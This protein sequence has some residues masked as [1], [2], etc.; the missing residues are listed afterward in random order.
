[1]A[2]KEIEEQETDSMAEEVQQFEE[3]L[4]ADL[5]ADVTPDQAKSEEDEGE[6]ESAEQITTES[7][8]QAK[9]AEEEPKAEEAEPEEKPPETYKYG[10]REFTAQEL[11]EDP[12]LLRKIVTGAEQNPHFQKLHREGKEANKELLTRLETI[13]KAQE[14]AR[15]SEAATV[16]PMSPEQIQAHSAQIEAAYLPAVKAYADAG[17]IE[18]DFVNMFPKVAALIESK[19]A[20]MG[21]IGGQMAQGMDAVLGWASGK[22]RDSGQ[23]EAEAFVGRQFDAMIATGK[24]PLQ[25]L[26]DPER[27]GEFTT[28]LVAEDNPLPYK[29]MDVTEL[30]PD[31]LEQAY[32]N[33]LKIKGALETPVAATPAATPAATAPSESVLATGGGS[34]GRGSQAAQSGVDAFLQAHEND[35][36]R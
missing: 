9:P 33:F 6:K 36:N 17:G 8:D 11:S 28:W 13:E 31:V 26:K 19:F 3:A 14:A 30:T 34:G 7:E 10:D 22:E 4:T 23:T 12:E 29:K 18:P 21:H 24:Q 2:D 5:D 25:D 35:L 20:Q 32:W 1:M 15:A 27:R 16:T